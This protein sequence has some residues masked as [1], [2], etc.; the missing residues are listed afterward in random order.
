[1]DHVTVLNIHKPFPIKAYPTPLK[2]RPGQLLD[3][4]VSAACSVLWGS[5]QFVCFHHKG[6]WMECDEMWFGKITR[7]LYL[8]LAGPFVCSF[9]YSSGL[10]SLLISDTRIV[11]CV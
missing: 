10:Y 9:L 4:K 2:S 5:A 11:E 8:S 3:R 6:F 7:E 1:M